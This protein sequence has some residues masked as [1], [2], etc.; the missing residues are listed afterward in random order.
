VRAA[1]AARERVRTPPSIDSPALHAE[2]EHEPMSFIQRLFTRILPRSWAEGMEA[3][4]RRWV[5]RCPCGFGRSIWEL[6]GI[7]WKAAGSKRILRRC[8]RCGK[9]GW[10][11]LEKT[12]ASKSG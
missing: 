5:L 6:G 12:D 3:E 1:A 8:A 11:T 10:H 2:P 9:T 4:S 7:R